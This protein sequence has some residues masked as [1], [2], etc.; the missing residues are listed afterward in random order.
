MGRQIPIYLNEEQRTDPPVAV[1]PDAY[2]L[3]FTEAR[4]AGA[5]GWVFHTEAG[6]SLGQR[7]FLEALAPN[8]RAALP[9]LRD[10]R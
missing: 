5:A 6:F 10:K 3:A 2:V 1:A 8:E 9:R 4:Q 7:P